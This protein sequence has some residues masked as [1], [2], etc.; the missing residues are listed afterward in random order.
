MSTSDL[1]GRYRKHSYLMRIP[2]R[3]NPTHV[4]IKPSTKLTLKILT[5][6]VGSLLLRR[7]RRRCKDEVNAEDPSF[8]LS[9]LSII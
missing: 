7:G 8:Q 5:W 2:T 3:D 9:D 1:K 4:Q 6:V